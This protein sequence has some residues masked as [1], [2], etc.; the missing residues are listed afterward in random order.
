MTRSPVAAKMPQAETK[1]RKYKRQ[2]PLQ[3]RIS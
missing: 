2:K 3:E 1:Y